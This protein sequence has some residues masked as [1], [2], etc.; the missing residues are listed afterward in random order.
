MTNSSNA[1]PRTRSKALLISIIL[2]LTIISCVNKPKPINSISNT[3]NTTSVATAAIDPNQLQLNKAIERELKGDKFHSYTIKLEANQY[4]NAVVEQK[5]IDIVAALYSPSG[6]KVYEVDSPNG[7]EGPEPIYFISQ[8]SGVYRLEVRSLEKE[9]KTGNYEVKVNE[10]RASIAE[11]IDRVAG[12]KALSEATLLESEGKQENEKLV[13]S[14]YEEAIEK[15]GKANELITKVNGI[16]SLARFYKNNGDYAKAEFL[17]IQALEINKKV[18]GDNHHDTASSMSNL[19][20]LYYSK[21]DYNKAEPLYIIALEIFRTALGD[22]HSETAGSM[23]NLANLYH[24]KGDYNKAEPLYIQ[25]LE[26]RKQILGNNHPDTATSVNNLG[27][28]YQ[29]K[30]EYDKAETLYIEALGICKQILGN[31]HPDTATS[32][33]SLAELYRLKGNYKKA[34]TLG[35]QALKIRRKVLRENHPDIVRSINNLA[36]LYSNKGDYTK[37]ESLY[38][39]ILG[40]RRKTLG[41]NHP[42][43]ANSINN[44]AAVYEKKGDYSKA[45][46]MYMQSIEI[47]RKV[48]KENHPDIAVL[49]S[50]LAIIYY[51]KGDYSKA[52]LFYIESMKIQKE[53]LGENHPDTATSINN[54]ASLYYNKKDYEKAEFL[55]IK[56]LDIRKH[57]LGENHP[58]TATSINNLAVLYNDKG[59]YNKSEPLLMKTLDIRKHIL[60]ENHP[61][62]TTSMNNLASLYYDKKDYEKAEFLFIKVLE[63]YRKILGDNHPSITV[64]LNNLATLYSNKGDYEKAVKYSREGNDAREGELSINLSIGSEKSKQIYLQKYASETDVALSLHMQSVPE[65]LMARQS[66]LTEILRRKGRSIDAVNQSVEALRKRSSPEDVAL[67]DELSQKNAFL[68]NLTIQGLGKRT[69]EEYKKLLESVRE[70]IE[71]LQ[72]KISERSAEFRT[73]SKPITLDAVQKLIPKDATLVEFASYRP[74]DAKART[75][76]TPRYVVYLLNNEG[77][78]DWVDLRLA[79]PIDKLVDDLRAKLRDGTTSVNREIKPLARKLDKLIMQPVRTPDGKLN[80]LPFAALVDESG[81]FLVENNKISYL[82][83]GRD[84][85]RLDVKIENKQA[86]VIIGDPDFGPIPDAASIKEGSTLYARLGFNRLASTEPEARAIKELFPDADLLLQ[87][88]ATEEAI[89]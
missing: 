60:G 82:T 22:N 48:L 51:K 78:P 75:Y 16:D 25:A 77:E 57:I 8:T 54:L 34:E 86:P 72:Y 29:K 65:N 71:T 30:G 81:K 17:Y 6:E 88:Q 52:E 27:L 26:I 19:A 44:L 41:E 2:S 9:A 39:Q 73:L 64:P 62:T 20:N 89:N 84:L 35:S 50:N 68:S 70:E 31:N 53:T 69:P 1:Y 66:A 87:Q 11:D 46:Q 3:S 40:I 42:D 32:M 18:L 67:L 14:K 23:S 24:S 15:L 33:A 37:A 4:L 55:F 45:E 74:Y 13:I 10:L 80:L 21:E 83:S 58:D 59:D 63:N 7:S 43:T 47:Y 61:N 12:F 5:G 85:L 28:F 49:I 56:A 38:I 36:L 76:G 79:E